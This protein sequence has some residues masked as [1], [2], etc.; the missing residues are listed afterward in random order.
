MNTIFIISIDISARKR[1][2][3]IL[4]ITNGSDL[5]RK[6]SDEASLS[7]R[8]QHIYVSSNKQIKSNVYFM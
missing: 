7:N 3:R 2:R 5:I 4:R 8:S 6:K 1:V